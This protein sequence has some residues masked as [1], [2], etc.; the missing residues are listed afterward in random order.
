MDYFRKGYWIFKTAIQETFLIPCPIFG[1]K[2][3][4]DIRKFKSPAAEQ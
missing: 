1:H 3:N 4:A 2:G